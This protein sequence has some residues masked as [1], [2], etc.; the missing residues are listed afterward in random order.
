MGYSSNADYHGR[1]RTQISARIHV[2]QRFTAFWLTVGHLRTIVL[3]T[4][5]RICCADCVR[6]S[7]PILLLSNS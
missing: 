3:L 6:I 1:S 5:F 7:A 4:L 2:M